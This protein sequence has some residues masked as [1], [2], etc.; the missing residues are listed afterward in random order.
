M[1]YIIS[2]MVSIS[3]LGVFLINTNYKEV[4]RSI[5]YRIWQN[6]KFVDKGRYKFPLWFYIISIISSFIYIFNYF[7]TGGFVFVW[8]MCRFV[9]GAAADIK[10]YFD[11]RI[12]NRII[13]FLNKKI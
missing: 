1:G 5:E 12:I 8:L 9:E 7:Y 10:I 6:Y 11:N 2:V 4:D 3:I 13:D